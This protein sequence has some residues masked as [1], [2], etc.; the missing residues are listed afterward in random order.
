[1]AFLDVLNPTPFGIFDSDTTF[2]SEADSMVLFVKR[3]LGGDVLSVELPSKTIWTAFEQ[4]VLAW[5]AIINE[6]DAKSNIPNVL[7]QPTGSDIQNLYP[8]ETLEFLLRQ[9]EPYAME[10]SYSGYQDQASG[11]IS[12]ERGR[13]DYN[14]RTELKDGNGTPLFDLAPSGSVGRMR[15]T[16]VFHFSP[17]IAFRFFDST[18]AINFLNNEFNFE[19][20]TPE[21]IFYML[22]VFEDILRQ[23]QLQLS[24]RVRRSNYSYRIV[25]QM[26]RIY[27]VPTANRDNP[28]KLFIRVAYAGDPYNF[29]TNAL[30]SGQD[31]TVNGISSLS[32]IPYGNIDYS[33]INA[34]GQQWVRD[35]TLA[36]CMISLGFIRGKVRNIPVPN[37]DVQL[38]YDDLLTRGYEDK[39]R[40]ITQLRDQL[41]NFLYYNLVEQQANKS[42]N[43]MRQL[44]GIPMPSG[45]F[46]IPG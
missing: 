45:K 13:Q 31:D 28:R 29:N 27:P 37:S 34:V 39:E 26:L 9:A 44:R 14:L 43:I 8:R 33:T 22:P 7:G 2:Q 41:E 19:S 36:L 4:A 38:N 6:F 30:G 46:I 35:Y 5:G 20:F 42:E 10:A 32:N 15:V 17:S 24:E 3:T 25:G 23:G 11:S 1:M 21:T 18:S 12:L 40:L 16:E